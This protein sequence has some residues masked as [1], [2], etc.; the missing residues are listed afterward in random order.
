MVQVR[1]GTSDFDIERRPLV[2]A[3][4]E[5]GRALDGEIGGPVTAA[6]EAMGRG[7]DLVALAAAAVADGLPEACEAV[8][9]GCVGI[10]TSAAEAATLASRRVAAVIWQ[11]SRPPVDLDLDGPPPV[12]ADA[13]A[14]LTRPA[15][16]TAWP[17]TVVV[18]RD[19]LATLDRIPA[20]VVGLVDLSGI[21]DRAATAAFVTVALERGA[22]GFVTPSPS[23]VRRAAH[24][25]RAVELAE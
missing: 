20:D 2:V 22:S 4:L 18:A 5:A 7:A 8:G 11:G 14:I 15:S 9:V 1:I 19:G 6:K 12:W 13:E 17:R 16:P 3:V 25:V 21:T 10:A 23:A 24:V